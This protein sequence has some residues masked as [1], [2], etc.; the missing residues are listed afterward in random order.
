MSEMRSIPF[1]FCAL[2]KRI[3]WAH[4]LDLAAIEN[5]GDYSQLNLTREL[6]H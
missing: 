2:P 5:D 1:S 4:I 3:A 6:F